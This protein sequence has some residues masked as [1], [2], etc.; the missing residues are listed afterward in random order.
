MVSVLTLPL[1]IGANIAVFSV[2]NAIL[3][4]PSGIPHAANLVALRA[5]YTAIPDLQ[6]ISISASDFGDAAGGKDVFSASAL[7]NEV[8]FNFS[9]DSANPELLNGAQVS[10]GYFDVFEARPAIG[11]VFT[12]EED[13][14]GAA[15]TA[16]LS[17]DAWKKRFGSDPGIVGASIEPMKALRTE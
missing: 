2:T 4:N 12:T 10:S 9:R 3:L 7:M 16:V 13:Q 8:S 15:K 1:G 6:S 5:H 11:R 17:H 14:P